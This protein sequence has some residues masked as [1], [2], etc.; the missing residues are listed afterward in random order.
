MVRMPSFGAGGDPDGEHDSDLYQHPGDGSAYQRHL[1]TPQR[2][3]VRNSINDRHEDSVQAIQ[4]G[5]VPVQELTPMEVRQ[6][7]QPG[8]APLHCTTGGRGLDAETAAQAQSLGLSP[9]EYMAA[10]QEAAQT[11]AAAKRRDAALARG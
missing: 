4:H 1:A 11:L 2:P 6:Y 7:H 8:E 9:S 5:A 10:R 3:H